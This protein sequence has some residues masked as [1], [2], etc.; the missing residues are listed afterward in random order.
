MIANCSLHKTDI[1]PA[2]ALA[3]RLL[4]TIELLFSVAILTFEKTHKRNT[5]TGASFLALNEVRLWLHSEY[6]IVLNIFS[7]IDTSSECPSSS[8]W[9]VNQSS[10]PCEKYLSTNRGLIIWP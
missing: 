5:I 3:S 1:E 9:I 4:F 10:F 7:Q 8:N 6:V 2:N